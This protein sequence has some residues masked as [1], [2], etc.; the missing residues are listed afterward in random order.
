[1]VNRVLN[2]LI[3]NS[4]F[5]FGARGTGKSTLIK[6]KFGSNSL[7]LDLLD[8]V[9]EDRLVRKPEDLKFL[10]GSTPPE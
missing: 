5:L 7:Y 10:I 9:L 8:P 6:D 2:P 4:F 3:N 1:M